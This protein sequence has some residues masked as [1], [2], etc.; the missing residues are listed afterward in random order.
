LRA[1]LLALALLGPAGPVSAE[2]LMDRNV[3]FGALAYEDRA[4]PIFVGQRHPAKVSD[5]V[6]YGLGPEGPQ[7]GWDIIPAIIDIRTDR[8]VIT[9]PD[10]PQD[11]FPVLEFNGYVL[12][13][14]TECVLFNS[15]AQN[16]EL[17]TEALSEDAVFSEISQLF[18]DMSG[19][20]FG[21]DTFIVIDVDVA[22]CPLG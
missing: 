10:I 9:Y 6:E 3:S 18:I 4:A 11:S 13:F 17:S 15:A 14:L 21:P 2:G 7:N 16:V 1:A 5:G 12:D 8:I 19:V 22:P 20:T